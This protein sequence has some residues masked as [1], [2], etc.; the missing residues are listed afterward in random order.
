M[1]LLLDL[2]WERIT[3]CK[4]TGLRSAKAVRLDLQEAVDSGVGQAK[5]GH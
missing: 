1:D 3:N 2:I 4:R 5:D